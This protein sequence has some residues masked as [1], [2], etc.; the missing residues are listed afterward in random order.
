MKNYKRDYTKLKYSYDIQSQMINN[1]TIERD[2]LL[3]EVEYLKKEYQKLLPERQK[4]MN[5]LI[6]SMGMV[7]EACAK[8]IQEIGK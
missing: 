3:K 5:Y 1:L 8:I 2:K 6:Q 7:N 4:V